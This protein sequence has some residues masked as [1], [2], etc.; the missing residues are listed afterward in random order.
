MTAKYE[1]KPT[2]PPSAVK[3]DSVPATIDVTS[4]TSQAKQTSEANNK[5]SNV[6]DTW[7]EPRKTFKQPNDVTVEREKKTCCLLM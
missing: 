3:R 2:T 4:E 5:N 7:E 6:N 1:P